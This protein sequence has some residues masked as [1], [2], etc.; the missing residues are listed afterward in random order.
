[1]KYAIQPGN[2]NHLAGRCAIMRAEVWQGPPRLDAVPIGT[3]EWTRDYA[4]AL[5]VTLPNLP[6]Y[7]DAMR[8]WL[9]RSVRR[10]V[11]ADAA[12]REF[13]KPVR[14]KAFT[15]AIRS[16]ITEDV[17]AQEPCWISAPVEWESEWRAYVLRGRVMALTRYDNRDTPG[18][19]IVAA[20][21]AASTTYDMLRAYGGS[22]AEWEGPAG[23]A[24]DYG[25]LANGR[26]SLVEVNDGWALG[27]YR[28]E[29][30]RD[31]AGVEAV[32][33]DTVT[34]RWRELCAGSEEK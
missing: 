22:I 2:P 21:D 28:P 30:R 10:G 25:Y 3:V 20:V 29:D 5:G 14:C 15:G 16:T 19:D 12:D 9:R 26:I 6:T 11:F 34:A 24:L 13:V 27:L 23:L 4:A 17:D 18:P 1:M 31:I 8:P 33:L 7:P 32:Y